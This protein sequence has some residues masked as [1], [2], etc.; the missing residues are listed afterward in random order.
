MANLSCV[1]QGNRLVIRS[2]DFSLT[3]TDTWANQ[4]GLFIVLRALRSSETGKPLFTDQQLAE[5]FGYPSRQNIQN[6]GQEFEQS[7]QDL[8][9]YLQRKRKVD[10]SVVEAVTEA[11]WHR[12]RANVSQLCQQVATQ[13]ARPDLPAAS[14]PPA[15]EEGPCPVI[16]PILQQQ[17]AEGTFHPTAEVGLP[18]A[19]A[20]L[21]SSSASAVVPATVAD[22]LPAV[23]R[24]P[25]KPTEEQGVQRQQAAA[26]AVLLNPQA[27]VAPGSATIRLM[28]LAL[29]LSFWNVPLSRIGYWCGGSTS[30]VLT[31]VTGLAVALYPTI[32]AWIV[33]RV[34]A[35]SVARDE[36]W[37]K[38]RQVWHDWFV[39]LDEATELPVVMALLPTRPTWACGWV[40]VSRKRLRLIPRAISPEGL[41]GYRA[42]VQAV[43]PT[44][45][46]LLCGVHQ[47]PGVTRWLRTHAS[48]LP[49][50]VVATLKRKMNR[51]RQTCD[52][53][54]VRR[55]FTRLAQE[56][57]D[58][59]CGLASWITQTQQR[60]GNLFPALR[61]NAFPRTTT[62]I[63]RFFRAFQRVYKTRGGFHSVVSAQREWMVFVVVYV[64][65]M[66]ANTGTAP[67]ERILPQANQ[68]PVYKLLNDPFPYGLA[69][70]CQAK[71]PQ[72]LFLATQHSSLEL[73]Q[74]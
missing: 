55:R 74:A 11:V 13:V 23:G 9:A 17:W 63:E 3:R 14:I 56:E 2:Q 35:V 43:L 28:V 5:A 70:S 48:H 64:F 60:L 37:L 31:W 32:Q 18:A 1:R 66:Q 36:K 34:T 24:A 69:N 46:H 10:S 72:G 62:S 45:K 12:P 51:V 29:T 8:L 42:S 67:I 40:L 26:R 4:K 16:R 6:F 54:P 61:R 65:T 33:P 59:P 53:R 22:E 44:T 30:T 38:I 27:T 50:E 58:P 52:P 39:G 21:L 25:A 20:A 41:G 49:D 7:G 73:K 57:G 68:R 19:F 47:Q 15:L 71:P